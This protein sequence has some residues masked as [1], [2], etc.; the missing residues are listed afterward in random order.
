MS[1]PRQRGFTL[2]EVL[3]AVAVLALALG[4]TIT[5]ASQYAANASYLRDKAIAS[6]VARN[7]LVELHLN[8]SWPELGKSDGTEEMAGREW[9]WRMQVQK[10]P[11]AKVRRVDIYVDAPR[12]NK[13]KSKDSGQLIMMSGFLTARPLTP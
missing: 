4:A 6:W 12:K 13:S 2:I 5:G 9:N 7:K 10:T 3:A 8:P 1:T 11:D